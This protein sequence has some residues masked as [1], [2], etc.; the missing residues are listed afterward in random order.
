MCAT[1]VL[2][3]NLD[4][5]EVLLMQTIH[6]KCPPQYVGIF[7]LRDLAQ[8]SSLITLHDAEWNEASDGGIKRLNSNWV[9]SGTCVG[10]LS[11]CAYKV[12]DVMGVRLKFE[13]SPNQEWMLFSYPIACCGHEID[14]VSIKQ[15]IYVYRHGGTLELEN[16]E[17]LKMQKGDMI[18]IDFEKWNDHESNITYMYLVQRVNTGSQY[19]TELLSRASSKGKEPCIIPNYKEYALPN[20]LLNLQHIVSVHSEEMSRI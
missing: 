7:W 4:E 3:S 8:S 1:P 12:F 15:W 13:I 10:L 17:K 20:H 18:R 9:K 11:T 6:E 19:R 14:I 2:L 5:I 16:G